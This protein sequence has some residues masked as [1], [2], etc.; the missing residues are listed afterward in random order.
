MAACL[1]VVGTT[2]T[3]ANASAPNVVRVKVKIVN[4]AFKPQV[5]SVHKGTLV[6]WKNTTTT[7]SHTSTSDTGAWDS[8]IIPPGGKFKHKFTSVGTF[9][10]HC[11]IHPTMMAEVDVSA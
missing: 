1:L 9:T 11:A 6:I 7:T 2:G 10:Y 5:L 8:G 3:V 4:F